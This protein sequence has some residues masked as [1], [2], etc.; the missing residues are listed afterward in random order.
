MSFCL[1]SLCYFRRPCTLYNSSRQVVSHSLND[2]GPGSLRQAIDSAQPGSTLTFDPNLKGTI[3]L[4]TSL[5]IT[6]NLTIDGSGPDRLAIKY[7]D[8]I[9]LGT[10]AIQL[11]IDPRVTVQISGIAFKD[12]TTPA[13][14]I[15]NEGTLL[16]DHCLITGNTISAQGGSIL[17]LGTLT[18]SNSSI[19]HNALKISDAKNAFSGL[20]VNNGGTALLM[21]SDISDNTV[22]SGSGG[23]GGITNDSGGN[24]ILQQSVISGNVVTSSQGA[25]GGG[26]YTQDKGTIT[27]SNSTISGNSVNGS[28]YAFGGGIA[29]VDGTLQLDNSTVSGNTATSSSGKTEGGGIF[30]AGSFSADGNTLI[31]KPTITLSD[32][33]VSGNSATGSQYAFGGGIY[34]PDGTLQLNNSTV[35]GNAATSSNGTTEGGGIFS[36]GSLS[37]DG[38]TLISKSTITFNN[39]TISGNSLIS[40]K[41]ISRGAGIE[42]N[43]VQG[44]ITFCTIYGNTATATASFGGGI[45]SSANPVDQNHVVLGNTIV[46]NNHA[47]TD[48]DLSGSLITNGYNLIQDLSSFTFADPLNL[49]HTDLSGSTFPTLGIDPQLKNNGGAT[50]NPCV[51]AWKPRH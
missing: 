24:I 2:S 48:S 11:N 32:S 5:V 12:S 47:L 7:K 43:G 41:D 21:N 39:S 28:Q 33:T 22:V 20:I 6:K 9:G 29:V 45:G 36:G 18:L 15:G 26:I 4:S 8:L 44:T 31:S 3:D 38:K 10:P 27:L 19:S 34:A 30:S 16:L 13:L 17:N 14:M 23:G 37:N 50:P 1:F 49:H 40:S 51:T 46:A 42:A 25:S 35:S